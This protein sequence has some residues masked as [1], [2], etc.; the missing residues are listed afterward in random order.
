MKNSVPIS[1][2]PQTRFNRGSVSRWSWTRC[3]ESPK[4]ALL[5]QLGSQPLRFVQI[6]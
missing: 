1:C 4:L 5:K 3:A 6:I 2:L